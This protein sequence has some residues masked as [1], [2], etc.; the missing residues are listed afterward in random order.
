MQAPWSLVSPSFVT[1]LRRGLVGRLQLSKQHHN[2]Q[3]FARTGSSARPEP[4]PAR[5]YLGW[6]RT[7]QDWPALQCV[8]HCARAGLCA[9]AL[10]C[11]HGLFASPWQLCRRQPCK[12]CTC[13][14]S[15][16]A[17]HLLCHL[18]CGTVRQGATP[19]LPWSGHGCKLLL[20]VCQSASE[21]ACKHNAESQTLPGPYT[22]LTSRRCHEPSRDS[23]CHWKQDTGWQAI[24]AVPALPGVRL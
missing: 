16:A 13:N 2:A 24:V 7:A 3:A 9:L 17:L 8:Q 6:Q 22:R 5:R 1:C 19:Y 15:T 11:T 12:A 10:C 23:G 20:Q 14:A 18:S 4:D 21:L